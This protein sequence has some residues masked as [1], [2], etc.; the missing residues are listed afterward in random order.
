MKKFTPMQWVILIVCFFLLFGNG[1]IPTFGGFSVLAKTIICI[2]VGT[3]L[4]LL[5]I[6]TVWP[7]FLCVMALVFCNVYSLS[8]AVVQFFGSTTCAMIMMKVS[9]N[10]LLNIL[11][12]NAYLCHSF[13]K[14]RALLYI[15]CP[16]KVIFLYFCPVT[17]S[18]IHHCDLAI[19]IVLQ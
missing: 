15:R 2:F 4:L 7:T 11:R 16:W 12:L 3:I 9:N 17:A 8:D 14:G 1:L 13:C 5:T 19:V 6:N 18:C 10:D